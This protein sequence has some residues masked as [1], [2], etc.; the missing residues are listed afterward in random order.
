Y[1]YRLALAH[2]NLGTLYRGDRRWTDAESAFLAAAPLWDRL[3]DDHKDVVEYV[4]FAAATHYNLG[5]TYQDTDPIDLAE[6]SFR[7]AMDAYETLSSAHPLVLDY[8][9][10]VG[11]T[12][13]RLGDMAR[14]HDKPA[15]ALPWFDKGQKKLE[16]MLPRD[17]E[18]PET[19][20]GLRN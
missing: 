14:D 6:A 5:L 4:R 10:I 9:I 18:R 1:R 20:E 2:N 3:A 12:Y 13:G 19:R 16:A 7:R 15:D 8:A 11:K 17:P